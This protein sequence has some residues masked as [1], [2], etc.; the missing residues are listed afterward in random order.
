MKKNKLI[1]LTVRI[2]VILSII[3]GG[4]LYLWNPFEKSFYLQRGLTLGLFGMIVGGISMIIPSLFSGNKIKQSL[5]YLI[6]M[7]LLI[8][9][10]FVQ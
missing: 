10:Y 1:L 3:I 9:V 2:A 7:L 5:L 6:V 8:I 4:V